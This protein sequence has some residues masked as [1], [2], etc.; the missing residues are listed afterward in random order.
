[1]S[2]FFSARNLAGPMIVLLAQASIPCTMFFS[3]V[4]LKARYQPRCLLFPLHLHCSALCGVSRQFAGVGILI[5][6]MIVAI[7]PKFLYPPPPPV[8]APTATGAPTP[9]P[10]GGGP[11][12][13]TWIFLYIGSC[14][15]SA[16][17]S[18]LR[19]VSLFVWR[20]LSVCTCLN[21]FAA[22][23]S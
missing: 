11:G 22:Y 5:L 9:P 8:V 14:V 16:V 13:L 3:F 21:V 23:I 15:P 17:S 1:M 4:M 18:V 2:R 19:E 7:M 20:V 6:G 10:I 12:E